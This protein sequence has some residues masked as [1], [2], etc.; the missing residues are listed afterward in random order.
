VLARFLA[1]RIEDLKDTSDEGVPVG[2]ADGENL[3][4]RLRFLY[5]WT[6]ERIEET[7]SH[8]RGES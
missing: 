5:F 7:L 6:Q 4:K 8:L 1:C 3:A 2:S